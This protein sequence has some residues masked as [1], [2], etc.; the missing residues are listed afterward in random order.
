MITESTEVASPCIGKCCLNTADICL[1][2]FRS[3]HEITA[4]SQAPN[5]VRQQFLR[6]AQQRNAL[7][8]QHNRETF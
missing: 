5:T 2:C 4:W 8:N 6:N 1:G 7:Y 3:I